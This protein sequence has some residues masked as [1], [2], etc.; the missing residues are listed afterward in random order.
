[1]NGNSGSLSK[2]KIE[3]K[4]QKKFQ[5]KN[6]VTE[7]TYWTGSIADSLILHTCLQK[8][9]NVNNIKR[10][11]W[12]KMSTGSGTHGTPSKG[13]TCMSTVL[14]GEEK[15]CVAEKDISRN[16]GRKFPKFG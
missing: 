13:L 7:K 16:N 8:L 2:K 5:I 12:Q 3:I 15:E 1:M 4:N 14:K 10:N 6:T 9:T 11:S